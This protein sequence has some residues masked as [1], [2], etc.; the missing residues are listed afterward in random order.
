MAGTQTRFCRKHLLSHWFISIISCDRWADGAEKPW[1]D[2]HLDVRG[3]AAA[4]LR[5]PWSSRFSNPSLRFRVWLLT[6]TGVTTTHLGGPLGS[7]G[8][9][10]RRVCLFHQ[11]D[12]G[13]PPSPSGRS[14]SDI[15]PTA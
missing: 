4:A 13:A 14:E 15:A 8:G 10:T 3:R 7:D 9:N 12:C 6:S 11:P 1:V 5:N 2:E